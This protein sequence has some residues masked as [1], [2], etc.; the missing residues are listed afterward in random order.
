MRKVKIILI[1]VAVVVSI[2]GAFAAK[3]TGCE[4]ST[5]YVQ[6]GSSY[7]EAGTY[8]IDFVCLD[9]PGICTYYKP[10]PLVEA[11]YPC[12]MGTYQSLNHKLKG[13]K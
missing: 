5:Q 3:Q 9:N 7:V 2:G 1:T 13:K 4:Y 10:N 6:S 12:R 8:G 11:Y